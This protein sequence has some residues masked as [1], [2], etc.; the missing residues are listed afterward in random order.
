MRWKRY[1]KDFGE[2]IPP[3]PNTSRTPSAAAV[4]DGH[5]RPIAY[6]RARYRSPSTFWHAHHGWLT[7]PYQLLERIAAAIAALENERAKR[8]SLGY[9]AMDQA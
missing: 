7:I 3:D 8:R 9:K 4:C 5:D 1:S 2:P 6:L